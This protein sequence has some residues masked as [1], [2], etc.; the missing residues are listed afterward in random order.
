MQTQLCNLL[1]SLFETRGESFYKTP[2]FYAMKILKEHTGQYLADLLYDKNDKDLDIVASSG[3]DGRLVVSMVN[4]NLYEG[5]D[6]CLNLPEGIRTC[7]EARIVSCSDV[8]MTNSFEKPD[9]IV[10]AP[11]EGLDTFR[12]NLPPFSIVRAVFTGD[13]AI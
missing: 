1:Q 7:T 9:N 4:E 10:D 3:D 13:T 8:R 11:W 2:T 12:F 5:K 6:L